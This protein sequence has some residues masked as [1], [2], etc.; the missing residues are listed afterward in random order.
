MTTV[1]ILERFTQYYLMYIHFR[2]TS[3]SKTNKI[4]SG[5]GNIPINSKKECER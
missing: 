1:E 3:E 5:N 4:S 2:H